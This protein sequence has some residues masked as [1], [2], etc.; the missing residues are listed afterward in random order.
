MSPYANAFM[1]ELLY[2]LWTGLGQRQQVLIFLVVGGGLLTM[3]YTGG[4]LLVPEWLGGLPPLESFWVFMVAMVGITGPGRLIEEHRLSGTLEHLHLSPVPLGYLCLVR[5]IVGSIVWLPLFLGGSAG[6]VVL[7]RQ[8]P[9][10]SWPVG[11]AYALMLAGTTGLGYVFAGF[12]LL[13]A[14]RVGSWMG[15]AVL[16]TLPLSMMNLAG[17]PLA[18]VLPWLLPMSSGVSVLQSLRAGLSGS[19]RVVLA[20]APL[21]VAALVNLAV[22]LAMFR[23]AEWR[24][25]EN[26]TL[27][28][29]V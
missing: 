25:R 15:V 26:G 4:G 6:L 22:G 10:L 17:L 16:V 11:I 21:A 5:T 19:E 1:G 29:Y 8:S 27:T 13:G 18:A 2:G 23:W 14:A 12:S 20:F 28:R 9:N 3:V 24:A 7:T